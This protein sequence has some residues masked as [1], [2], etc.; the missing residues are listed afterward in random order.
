[1]P[2]DT[3]LFIGDE[4]ANKS[5]GISTLMSTD[6]NIVNTGSRVDWDDSTEPEENISY[7]DYGELFDDK[8]KSATQCCLFFNPIKNDSLHTALDNADSFEKEYPHIQIMLVAILPN[9][10]TNRQNSA[11]NLKTAQ[12][13]AK[14]KRISY[15]EI[16]RSKEGATSLKHALSAA[17]SIKAFE[18]WINKHSKKDSEEYKAAHTIITILKNSLNND[19]TKLNHYFKANQARIDEQLQI[20]EKCSNNTKRLN[21]GATAI[22]CLT[23][24]ALIGLLPLAYNQYK[25]GNPFTFFKN[26]AKQQATSAI[27]MAKNAEENEGGI[28]PK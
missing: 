27:E 16:D 8:V 10:N 23:S 14:E 28:T 12:N 24:L 18:S 15:Y 25:H 5:D 26:E 4:K 2:S 9:P 13:L 20:L 11:L 3:I 17:S 6:S 1:M 7:G 19:K 21:Y 22:A